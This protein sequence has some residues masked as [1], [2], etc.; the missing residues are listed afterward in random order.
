M[1]QQ[2]SCRDVAW[3]NADCIKF[4]YRYRIFSVSSIEYSDN[5]LIMPITTNN[6]EMDGFSPV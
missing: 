6:T 3:I 2:L 5:H 4:C 1:N